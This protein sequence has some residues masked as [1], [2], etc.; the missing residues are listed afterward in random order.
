MTQNPIKR[1]F[2]D[3]ITRQFDDPGIEIDRNFDLGPLF[4][5]HHRPRIQ[6]LL[7]ELPAAGMNTSDR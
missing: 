2:S 7:N 4:L 1:R 5:I 6:I 3:D